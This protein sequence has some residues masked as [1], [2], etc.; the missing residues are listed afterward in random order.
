MRTASPLGGLRTSLIGHCGE[1]QE[2]LQ[3]ALDDVDFDESWP[4]GQAKMSDD[5]LR[6]FVLCAYGLSVRKAG[7]HMAAV[8]LANEQNNVA[9]LGVHA[10]VL[11]ECA[12]ELVAVAHA[13]VDGTPKALDRI[14]NLTEFDTNR[15]LRR[16]TRGEISREELE[17]GITR[18]REAIGLFDGRQPKGTTITD[19]VSILTQGKGWYDYLSR[20]FCDSDVESLGKSPGQGG[21]VPAPEL[22]FDLAVAVIL[23]GTLTYVC[24]MLIAYGAIRIKSGSGSQL[25]D[26]AVALFD[27]VR[28]TA[29]PIRSGPSE[30][31]RL[32]RAAGEASGG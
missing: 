4:S 21:V 9:S 12:A 13:Y 14:L 29:A 16:I 18:A 5:E 2:L 17:A 11:I 15:L 32:V 30:V 22:Q 28:E 27:R 19:R 6:R 31:A 26:D 23:N 24:Q 3:R 10:R 8:R 25:F 7:V 1:A 20:H